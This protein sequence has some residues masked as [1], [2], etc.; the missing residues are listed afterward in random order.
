MNCA[1]DSVPGKLSGPLTSDKPLVLGLLDTP[2]V[3]GDESEASPI[4]PLDPGYNLRPKLSAT[5]FFM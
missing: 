1:Y 4:E 5:S 3:S 2:V